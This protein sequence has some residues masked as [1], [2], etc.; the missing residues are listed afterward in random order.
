MNVIQ[1]IQ[2]TRKRMATRKLNKR[3]HALLEAMR[4]RVQLKEFRGRTYISLDGQPVLHVE[5]LKSS[6]IE[7]LE[8]IRTAI[9]EYKM[10]A[11]WKAGSDSIAR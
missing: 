1:L 10:R 6:P 11:T 2:T 4:E 8:S 3:K 7:A 9:V 5:L